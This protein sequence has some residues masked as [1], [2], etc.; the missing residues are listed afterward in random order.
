MTAHD[1]SN[2]KVSL[3]KKRLAAKG[4]MNKQYVAEISEDPDAMYSEITGSDI[5]KTSDL[6]AQ[7]GLEKASLCV[8]FFAT[9]MAK[10]P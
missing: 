1:V 3:K 7:I 6:V 4:R 2:A 10:T 8:K 5:L 9:Q